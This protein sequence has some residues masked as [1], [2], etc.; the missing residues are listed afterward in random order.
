MLAYS[1]RVDFFDV[2]SNVRTTGLLSQA[3]TNIAVGVAGS[4]VVLAGGQ[5]GRASCRERVYVLV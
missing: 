1:T 5:I 2:N 4:K 3:R